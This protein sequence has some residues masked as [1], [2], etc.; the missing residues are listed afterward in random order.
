M[1]SA[2]AL[3]IAQYV[4]VT[5]KRYATATIQ[6]FPYVTG[7]QDLY[8][9]RTKT[10]GPAVTITGRAILNPTSEQ[11]SAI[12]NGEVYDIAFLF[13]RIEMAAKFPT[14][15]EG[16]WVGV[17]GEATW[18][19]RRFRIVKVKPSGQIEDQFA[20]VVMLG[21]SIPGVRD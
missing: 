21:T 4:D 13:S 2:L 6:V 3:R 20:L 7:A 1:T 10:F 9:Q 5:L 15:A 12:G 11:V 18:W 19:G 14:S 16:E 17:S 8:H